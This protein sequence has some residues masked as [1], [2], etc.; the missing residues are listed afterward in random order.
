MIFLNINIAIGIFFLVLMILSTLNAAY[1]FKKLYPDLKTPK[2]H[3]SAC[4]L[5][6][7]KS[8]IVAIFP[9]LNILM[10]WILI[11]DSDDIKTKAIEKAYLECM[12]EKQDD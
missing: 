3:W 6:V 9:V 1:E 4:I 5:T 11:F 8:I 7:I 12:K 10:C 2:R